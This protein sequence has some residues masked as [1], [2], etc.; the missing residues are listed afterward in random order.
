MLVSSV[1]LYGVW[2]LCPV[3]WLVGVPSK[4]WLSHVCRGE[5]GW[6]HALWGSVVSLICLVVCLSHQLHSFPHDG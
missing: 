1:S 6:E 4:G 2:W 5:E 3:V